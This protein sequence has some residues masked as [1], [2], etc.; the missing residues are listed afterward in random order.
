MSD[1]G[2]N[3]SGVH[4]ATVTPMKA[5]SEVDFDMLAKYNDYLVNSGVSG[6][7]PLGST[8]EFYALTDDERR[9][10]LKGTIEAAGGRV[11]VIAGTNASSTANVIKYS[12]QAEKL[13]ADGLLLAAADDDSGP[14]FSQAS[15]HRLADTFARTGNQRNLAIELKQ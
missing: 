12:K 14:E 9:D 7:I 13:G 10:V 5:N 11:D 2:K 15:C 8:G 4:V 6:L 3:F 1:H